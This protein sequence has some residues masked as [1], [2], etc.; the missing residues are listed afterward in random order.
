MPLTKLGLK[1]PWL[2]LSAERVASE[3][4]GGVKKA[5][6]GVTANA[7]A[8]LYFA[9]KAVAQL[10]MLIKHVDEICNL[11]HIPTADFLIKG[12]GPIEHSLH[13]RHIGGFPLADV[14]IE[15]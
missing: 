5:A 15:G 2:R 10:N 1:R 12:H 14:L 3:E 13:G 9:A 4:A 8:V 7:G 11:A 6:V